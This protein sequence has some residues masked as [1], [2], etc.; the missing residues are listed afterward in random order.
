MKLLKDLIAPTVAC[1]FLGV[2]FALVIKQ[3]IAS[4]DPHVIVP[5][6]ILFIIVFTWIG[7]VKDTYTLHKNMKNI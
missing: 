1:G 6:G 7:I 5:M 3:M 2:F 4:Q